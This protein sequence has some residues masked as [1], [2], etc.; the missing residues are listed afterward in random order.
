MN[1]C[2]HPTLH[3][4]EHLSL[5]RHACLAA[6]PLLP[7]PP[8]TLP[9]RLTRELGVVVQHRALRQHQLIQ[10]QAALAVHQSHAGQLKP[11]RSDHLSQVE[12]MPRWQEWKHQCCLLHI[13]QHATAN[14]SPQLVPGLALLGTFTHHLTIRRNN[15]LVG[16][17]VC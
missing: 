11:S 16:C 17:L 9:R 14:I 13:S 5:M 8:P 12:V 3:C 6:S 4:S 1:K 10:Q 15:R 7:L 2:S